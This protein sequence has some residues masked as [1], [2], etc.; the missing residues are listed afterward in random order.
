MLKRYLTYA[1]VITVVVGGV[2]IGSGYINSIPSGGDEDFT[3][4]AYGPGYGVEDFTTIRFRD[5]VESNAEP[6]IELA[7]LQFLNISGE[8]VQ[9]R[10]FLGK[11]N[12]LLVMTRGYSNGICIYCSTQTSRLMSNYQQFAD[13]DAEVIVVYPLST[14]DDKLRADEFVS[15]A[16]EKLDAPLEKIPFPLVLDVELKAVDELGIRD[17]LAKPATFI[18]DKA[19][20]VRFSYI[21]S[22]IADRPSIQAMLDQLDALAETSVTRP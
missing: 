13:R 4:I 1:I 15:S 11:K 7:D 21:G 22:S 3:D 8:T 2:I 5:T 19:G 9:L 14:I 16:R 12:L 6:G 17:N 20:K 10:D 18:L